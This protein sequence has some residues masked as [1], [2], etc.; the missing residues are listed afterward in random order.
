MLAET[1]DW[2]S[3]A[4]PAVLIAVLALAVRL[5]LSTHRIPNMLTF[6][7]LAAGLLFAAWTDGFEGVRNALAGAAKDNCVRDAKVRY[8]KTS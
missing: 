1:A 4:T 5:D 7:A 2:L 6:G 3:L 8:G